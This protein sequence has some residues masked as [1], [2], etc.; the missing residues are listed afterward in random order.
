MKLAIGKSGA[1]SICVQ[2]VAR[3]STSL[4]MSSPSSQLSQT[5]EKNSYVDLVAYVCHGK[6]RLN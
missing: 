1:Y 5:S 6:P 2:P 4:S 3:A